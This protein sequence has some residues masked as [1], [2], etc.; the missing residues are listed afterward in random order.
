[1]GTKRTYFLF[2]LI[3]GVIALCFSGTGCGGEES[4]SD[5]GGT[6]VDDS[7]GDDNF[8]DR[9]PS[10]GSGNAAYSLDEADAF[11]STGI[12]EAQPWQSNRMAVSS[13]Q[14]EAPG[15]DGFP[16]RPGRAE[17]QDAALYSSYFYTFSSLTLFGYHDA[18]EYTIYRFGSPLYS[19]TL[20]DGEKIMIPITAGVYE[21][22][23][24][25]LISCLSGGEDYTGFFAV[26]DQSLAIG[27]LFYSLQTSWNSNCRQIVF[28]HHDDTAIEVYDMD[29]AALLGTTTL[30][31]GQHWDLYQTGY[32]KTVATKDISVLN[33]SDMGY[34]VAADTGLFSGTSFF[35]FSGT[36]YT[37]NSPATLIINSYAD[38]NEV[39]I[40]N[41]DTSAVVWSGTLMEGE[42]WAQTFES[43]YFKA[44]STDTIT[45]SS[46]SYYTSSFCQMDLAADQSGARIGTNFYF[47]TDDASDINIISYMDGNQI[48]LTDT[49]QTLMP[50]DDTIA[51]SGTLGEGGHQL[52][53]PTG[54]TQY[55]L[56][57]SLPATVFHSVCTLCGAE[58][59]PLYGM[60][61]GCEEDADCDNGEWCDGEEICNISTNIC[62]PGISPD[63]SDDGLFCNG[64]ES[65]NEDADICDHSGD[66]CQPGEYCDEVNDICVTTTTT[67]TTQPTTTTTTTSTT[68]TS[69]STTTFP[70]DDDIVSN[71]PVADEDEGDV[72]P[73]GQVT[74][75][76]CGCDG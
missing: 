57:S 50:F 40:T 28:A 11:Q 27:R 52:F 12:N 10:T 35:G 17:G 59:I 67:S 4:Y 36:A 23:T 37:S 49:N 21:L 69:T 71:V 38:N 31:A 8:P 74:G 26:N 24:S 32:F 5:G 19:G 61:M 6:E 3:F 13:Q 65:C 62:L 29:T 68:A 70:T 41:S 66:P 9:Y 48:V 76:C 60:I 7:A 30:D 53:S 64:D 39:T 25:D 16:S 47:N 18:T 54:M 55:H 20:N 14:S 1:M 42:M 46:I 2:L 43:L 58:F 63:C 15:H 56:E 73:E 45:V 75:G 34:T 22:V 51:W 33:F 72:W 44:Q